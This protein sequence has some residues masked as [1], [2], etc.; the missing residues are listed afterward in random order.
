MNSIPE[1]ELLASFFSEEK[2]LLQPRLP[3]ESKLKKLLETSLKKSLSFQTTPTSL[4]YYWD[5]R[6]FRLNTSEVFLSFKKELQ[7]QIL[8]N[9]SAHSLHTSHAIE[10]AA[11]TYCAR[12]ALLAPTL[13]EK[14]FFLAVG[15]EEVIHLVGFDQYVSDEDKIHPKSSTFAARFGSL[16]QHSDRETSFLIAQVLLEG[17]AMNHYEVLRESCI[18][19]SMKSLIDRVLNDEARHHGSGLVLLDESALSEAQIKNMCT[20]TREVLP[21]L[22]GQKQILLQTIQKTAAAMQTQ[23]K[24]EDLLRLTKEINLDSQMSDRTSHLKESIAKLKNISLR[25]ALLQIPE[26]RHG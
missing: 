13:D 15:Q 22:V 1:H 24:E 19:D 5:S 7:E 20:V 21:M 17:I 26:F 3:K 10:K 9:L 11:I 4:P 16:V 23:I 2:L 25:T 8:K 6:R 12:M 14:A 18:D